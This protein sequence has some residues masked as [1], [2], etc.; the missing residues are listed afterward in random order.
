MSE[1]AKTHAVVKAEPCDELLCGRAQQREVPLH[2]PRDIQH[3]NEP[4]RLRTIVE[5][6]NRLGPSLVADFEVL[7]RQIR[8]ES[9][10]TIRHGDED[11]NRVT[12]AAEDGLLPCS[13]AKYAKDAGGKCPERED[14]SHTNNSIG[15]PA[16]A[17]SAMLLSFSTP[18]PVD[19]GMG[20]HLIGVPV[21]PE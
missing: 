4:D 13:D 15:R 14:P 5:H 7:T 8:D 1:G 20:T 2:A 6:G 17:P 9:A 21:A 10:V 12:P 16:I 11:A 3:D 18:V 19:D